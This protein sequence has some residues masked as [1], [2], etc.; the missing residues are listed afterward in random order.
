MTPA[1]IRGGVIRLSRRIDELEKFDITKVQRRWA[2]EVKALEAAIEESLAAVFGEGSEQFNRYQAATS[3]D[4]GPISMGF[5]GFE[6]ALDPRTHEYLSEGKQQSLLLLRQAI[7]GLEES[8]EEASS[9]GPHAG[10]ELVVR[11]SRKVF[12]VH[13]H[14]DGPR[15]M[16]ARFLERI[17]FEPV[18]LH[19]QANQGRTIIEKVELH[20]DVPFAIVI[21]TPDDEG[22]KRGDPARPRARQNVVLELGYFIGRLGRDK[23]CALK[24]GDLEL[25]SDYAGVVYHPLEGEWR[26]ALA[27]ELKAAGFQIDWN[28][29]MG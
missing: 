29:V 6:P 26:Q 14:E 19:E 16:V 23:V 11:A 20:G 12:I 4:D 9:I 13:G 5:G 7:R 3:L 10:P 18:I 2:P 22:S 15:E 27:R 8:L 25:P 21:L 17:G 1:Q 28:L 24:Q